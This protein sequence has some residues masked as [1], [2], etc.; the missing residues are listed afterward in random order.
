MFGVPCGIDIIKLIAIVLS[1][2][3]E[4]SM[5]Q[6]IMEAPETYLYKNYRPVTLTS[7]LTKILEKS[8]QRI[9][10]LSWKHIRRSTISNMAYLICQLQFSATKASQQDIGGIGKLN[11]GT[12]AKV[13]D[14]VDHG[15]FLNKLK[16][17]RNQ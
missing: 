6:Y 12:F 1:P 9:S 3:I 4:S 10:I 14:R 17:N 8:L 7:H 11:N 13:L 5:H 2:F 16:K 15:I